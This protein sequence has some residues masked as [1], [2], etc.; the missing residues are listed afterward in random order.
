V[1]LVEHRTA[2]SPWPGLTRPSRVTRIELVALDGRLKAAHG[3]KIRD[4]SVAL[5]AKQY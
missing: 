5:F 3:E 1:N 2:T 4:K